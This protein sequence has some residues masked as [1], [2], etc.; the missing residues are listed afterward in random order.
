LLITEA[1]R[2]ES[3][4]IHFNPRMREQGEPSINL[5]TI[6]GRLIAAGRKLPLKHIGFMNLYT[7]NHN[8]LDVSIR[9]DKLE[10]GT[11]MNC[12]DP[13]NPRTV[14]FD[15][16][17]LKNNSAEHLTGLKMMRGEGFDKSHAEMVSKFSGLE[18][19][20]MVSKPAPPKRAAT[21]NGTLSSTVSPAASSANESPA[22]PSP[23][24]PSPDTVSVA[25]DYLVAL[26]NHHGHSLRIVLLHDGWLLGESAATAFLQ[27][28][29]NLEQVG[30]ACHDFCPTLLRRLLRHAPNVRAFRMLHS[31]SDAMW[32]SFEHLGEEPHIAALGME[33]AFPVY[34]RLRWI[35]HGSKQ[36]EIGPLPE[37]PARAAAPKLRVVK[38]MS[39][40]RARQIK[41]WGMD[42]MELL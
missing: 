23:Q 36:W 26:S 35:G 14:F 42:V 4:K 27:A 25:A 13:K 30:M 19:F 5:H 12:V 41:I 28:C 16:T 7:V 8:E 22:A 32:G 24:T 20:Y 37:E 18:E 21:S 39:R 3:L 2:L 31:Q 6:F 9:L 40:E 11:F 38:P 33:L 1:T 15:Q 10:S 17:W 29:P 34:R